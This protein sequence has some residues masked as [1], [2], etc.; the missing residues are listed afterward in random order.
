M[1]EAHC[2]ISIQPQIVGKPHGLRRSICFP[3]KGVKSEA[4]LVLGKYQPS[5]NDAER[6]FGKSRQQR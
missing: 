6:I 1:L 2:R 4:F 3:S 5:N